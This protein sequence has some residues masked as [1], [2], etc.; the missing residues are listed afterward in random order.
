M[1]SKQRPADGHCSCTVP[2]RFSSFQHRVAAHNGADCRRSEAFS[3]S[4]NI[5]QLCGFYSK[6]EQHACKIKKGGKCSCT[7]AT[8]KHVGGEM[9]EN[10]AKSN[11]ISMCHYPAGPDRD[12]SLSQKHFIGQDV[13]MSTWRFVSLLM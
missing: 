10:D 5:S 1:D 12:S 7:M 11:I 6:G 2:L 8:D 9:V 3:C 4:R 13:F